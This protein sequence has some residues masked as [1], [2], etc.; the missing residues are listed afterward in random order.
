V[1][2]S[3]YENTGFTKAHLRNVDSSYYRTM[4][5]LVSRVREQLA[6]GKRFIYLYYEG[7]DTTAHEFGLG[8]A[9]DTELHFVD[10]LLGRLIE[11]LPQGG[12]LVVTADH[13]QVEVKMP[14]LHLSG[15]ILSDVHYQ[16]GEGRFRWLH[17]RAGRAE[18]VKARC[19]D[20]YGK[21]AEI[22]TRGEVLA[23][24]IFGPRLNEDVARRLGDVALIAR[25][26][27]AFFD[28][29]DTGPFELVSRH[30]GL[31][32]D[33]IEVPLLSVSV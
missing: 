10:F 8:E 27:I 20:L 16:S 19:V 24:E 26:P 18:E 30:G 25:S 32:D 13:G 22:L 29:T 28:P 12:C 6:G 1:T 15:E 31:T 33:E 14:P 17:V 23:D 21:D 11:V 5:G 9:Y 4:S 7:I 3:L 2:K